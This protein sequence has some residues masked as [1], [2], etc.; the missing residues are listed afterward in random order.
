LLGPLVGVGLIDDLDA[1]EANARRFL[2][3]PSAEHASV[4]AETTRYLGSAGVR[5]DRFG[6]DTAPIRHVEPTPMAGPRRWDDRDGRQLGRGISPVTWT[7]T[8]G[9]TW[10]VT[11]P[12][13]CVAP[14]EQLGRRRLGLGLELR[15]RP[16]LRLQPLQPRPSPH[17]SQR[18]QAEPLGRAAE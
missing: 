18:T 17:R 9:V 5:P 10:G 4:D 6:Q 3:S 13:T 8:K 16:R 7:V 11:K 14:V 1:D 15:R 12:V 2:L